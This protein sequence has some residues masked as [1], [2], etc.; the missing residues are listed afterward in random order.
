MNLLAAISF[1]LALFASCLLLVLPVYSIGSSESNSLR[2]ATLLGVNGPL[3]L[4][5]LAIPVLI[6]LL[7]LLI[8]KFSARLIAGVILLV[9]AV[10]SGFSMGLFYFPSA[11]LMV[12]AGLLS[13]PLRKKRPNE[14]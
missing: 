8:P 1:G 6:A 12:M 3:A 2:H 4:V 7:P 14:K 10:I 5:A 13:A 9:F 11:I